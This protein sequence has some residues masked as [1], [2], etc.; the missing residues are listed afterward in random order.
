MIPFNLT[1]AVYWSLNRSP[2]GTQLEATLLPAFSSK[3]LSREGKGPLSPSSS[4][5]WLELMAHSWHIS[6]AAMDLWLGWFRLAQEAIF[7][8]PCPYFTKLTFFLPPL[9]L[10]GV[11]IKDSFLGWAL[12]IRAAA[13]GTL[14]HHHPL[15]SFRLYYSSSRDDRASGCEG[16]PFYSLC[17]W[18]AFPKWLRM[19]RIFRVY[20]PLACSLWRNDRPTPSF[21][22]ELGFLSHI[23]F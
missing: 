15:A 17:F 23:G 3:H 14:L 13:A 2:V 20:H 18:F 5:A 9:L 22:S 6:A 4:H 16:I 21:T 11:V 12:I 10:R 8:R 1:R 19:P 7:H